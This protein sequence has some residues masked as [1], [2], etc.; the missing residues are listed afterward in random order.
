[1]NKNF[2]VRGGSGNIIEPKLDARPQDNLYL[3]VNSEWI[4]KT[5]IPEDR[6]RMASFDGIDVD[7]EKH[8]MQD[9][10]DFAAGKKEVPSVPNFDEAVKLYK[11]AKDFDKRNS[12]GAEPIK[13]DLELLDGLKD[14]SDFNLNAPDLVTFAAIPFGLDVEPDMKNTKVNALNFA[15]PGTFLP[16]T[17]TYQTLDAPKLLGI[18]Q[19]QS[20]KLLTMAGIAEERA[21]KYA[22]DA[23]KFDKK[24]AKIVKS[25]EEWADYPAT[26]NPM[27]I[28]DFEAKFADFQISYFLREVIGEEPSRII[29]QEPRYLDHINEIINKENFAEIKGWM[30]V[31]FINGVADVLSQDFRE[32]S[33]P[34]AQALSGQPQLTTGEK[35][36]YHIANDSFS[37]VVGV[38]YGQTYFGKEAKE[39]VEDMIHRMLD[40]YKER[41]Q[42]NDWLSER[43]KKRAIIKLDALVLKIGYPDKIEEIY[44][45]LKVIPASQGGSLYSNERAFAIVEQKYNFEQLHKEVDR[46]VWA[47]PGNLVNACYD[48]QRNDLTFPAA[49]LQK[50][51][52]D[53][54]QD[55]AANFGG[56]GSVIAHEVSHA[57]DNNGAQFDEL[58]NMTNWWTDEDYAEFKKRTQAEIDLF[59]GIEYG[60]VTL[61]GKQ[62]VSE[63]IAD[64]GGLTAAVEAAK[65]ENDDLKKLFEN[66]ARIWANKQLT[67]S[68]K[69]QIAVDVHAPG[70]LRAN[71][72]SQCQD[73]FYKVFDVKPE[74]GMWLDPEKRVHIW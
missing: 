25:S 74:D 35:Q 71:V 54:K 51:F 11:L 44:N 24:L 31:N 23:I 32:A 69:S 20:V 65:N 40:V 66:F 41:L 13:S 36:A 21:E 73:D 68:I 3:A 6:S 42:N 34:F 7:V 72:Q 2:A 19:K 4:E 57:F 59:D 15:G 39:D 50:P 58:G 45:R 61:N 52:Y 53:L 16:D 33:F 55:R 63:N 56:I 17:T 46:T 18:L 29:V 37:E 12:D 67:E 38:Y 60:P 30:L 70:P 1:M 10:T 27:K 5:K 8:L 47:M 43:T 49:I 22:E 64:Q 62:I 14:F 28:A 26:Y 48:P 9:F